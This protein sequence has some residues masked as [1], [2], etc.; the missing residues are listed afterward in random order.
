MNLQNEFAAQRVR[1]EQRE[2]V[3]DLFTFSFVR[4]PFTR[5]L[6]CYRD[7]VL[8]PRAADWP[9]LYDREGLCFPI[10]GSFADF[11]E[12]V[13]AI[14]DVAADRHFKSQ[15]YSLYESDHCLVDWIGRIETIHDDWHTVAE[16]CDLPRTLAHRKKQQV[17][18]SLGEA[19]D[20]RLVEQVRQRYAADFERFGYSDRLDLIER[21]V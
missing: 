18:L 12:W 14:P 1:V 17:S 11:V 20:A 9:Y 19:Y 4:N 21:N 6:S 15:A 5:L 8:Y 2:A 13:A 10:D 7:K 16:R 3:A